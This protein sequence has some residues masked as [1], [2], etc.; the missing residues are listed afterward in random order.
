[1]I[2]ALSISGVG[3]SPSFEHLL[4]SFPADGEMKAWQWELREGAQKG[5]HMTRKGKRLL[6]GRSPPHLCKE[7]LPDCQSAS[8]PV[9]TGIMLSTG[10]VGGQRRIN[11]MGLLPPLQ[12]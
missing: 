5:S 1:M 9:Y 3:S 6:S 4:A 8:C 2:L 11:P 10:C 12:D 7:L